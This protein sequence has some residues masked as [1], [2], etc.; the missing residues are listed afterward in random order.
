MSYKELSEKVGKPKSIIFQILTTAFIFV[1]LVV[2]I[3]LFSPSNDIPWWVDICL[4]L[5]AALL[6]VFYYYYLAF[7]FYQKERLEVEEETIT[8]ETRR[9]VFITTA[10]DLLNHFLK[11]LKGDEKKMNVLKEKASKSLDP[12]LIGRY[13]KKKSDYEYTLFQVRVL[14]GFLNSYYR[15][16]YNLDYLEKVRAPYLANGYYYRTNELFNPSEEG[17]IKENEKESSI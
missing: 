11:R 1:A 17:E 6:W 13:L 16:N 3:R 10:K 12:F 15:E 2:I 5:V 4:L 9:E 8:E 14:S 7:V